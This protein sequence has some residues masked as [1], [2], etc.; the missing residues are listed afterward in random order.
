MSNSSRP[1]TSLSKPRHEPRATVKILQGGGLCLLGLM[2]LLIL[3]P[4]GANAGEGVFLL[5]NDAF[6]LGRASS[7]IASPRSAY[8]SYM[9]PASMVDLERRVDVNWYMVFTDIELRP[10]GVIG[11][12]LDGDLVSDGNFHIASGGIIWPLKTG[13]LGAGL[14]IPSGTGAEFP[15]SRNLLSRLFNADRRLDYQHL[16][17]VVAYAYEF[18]NGWALG[19][20]LH[21]SLSRFRSDHITLG[22]L[23]AQAGNDWD[24]AFGAGFN[25]GVYRSWE[26]WAFGATYT[27]RHWTQSLDKYS[28]LLRYTLDTPQIFQIGLSYKITPRLEISADYKWLN[29]KDVDAYGEKVLKGGFNWDDQHGFKVGLEWEATDKLRLMTGFAHSNTPVDKDHTM[30]AGLVPVLIE[31]HATVGAAYSLN[32]AHEVNVA[33]VY[34]IPNTLKDTGRGDIFSRLGRGTE[35]KSEGVSLVLGYTFKF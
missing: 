31:N 27:T 15:H 2:S 3:F 21:G 23:P 25:I 12:R 7:G 6:Q 24:E 8:W 1:L 9:N 26:R 28:D 22:L 35:I 4:G 29:W 5:G 20:G 30:I 34:G 17:A 33:A 13:T 10:R 32:D 16:R 11:N 19:A 14:Y 18:E